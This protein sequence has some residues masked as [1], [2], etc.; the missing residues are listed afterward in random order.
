M[1]F[2]GRLLFPFLTVLALT[3]CWAD[4]P[5]LAIVQAGVQASDDAP[6]ASPAYQFYPGDFLFFTFDVA[7]FTVKSNPDNDTRRISLK[8]TITPED[9]NSV[10]LAPPATGAIQ[11]ELNPEDKNWTPKR[12][13]N[14]HLP[15]FVAAGEYHV[16]AV[17]EDQFGK[18]QIAKDY[19]FRIGGIAIRPSPSLSVENFRFFRNPDDRQPL[20]VPAYSPG[21][22]IYAKFDMVGY[23]FGQDNQYHV[24]Y[25]LLVTRPDGKPFIRQPNAAN[26][27]DTSFY[28]AQ[29]VPGVLEL[30]T[31]PN[32]ERGAYII[33]LSVRDLI[34]NQTYEI[35]QSF[36]IEQ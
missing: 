34:G 20:E 28:P 21:D 14:F 15:S 26:L 19:P 7:G 24:A 18:T 3:P 31:P 13:A 23:K 9:S 30:T 17:V 6:F 22:K 33:I 10:A 4:E 8:Y 35:K 27:T 5:S 2:S 32:S 12:R 11:A 1:A 16:H 36:S 29:F 25:G